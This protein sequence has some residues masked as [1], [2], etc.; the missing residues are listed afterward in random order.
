MK[1]AAMATHNG[2]N[3]KKA[4]GDK[5]GIV[6]LEKKKEQ[7]EKAEG[8]DI[9]LSSA[10]CVNIGEKP[11]QKTPHSPVKNLK[12]GMRIGHKHDKEKSIGGSRSEN[13][14]LVAWHRYLY[15]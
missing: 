11:P 2:N 9:A 10:F 6:L 13:M 8:V 14:I 4:Q 7:S 5:G 1:K 12:K 3:H 15:V